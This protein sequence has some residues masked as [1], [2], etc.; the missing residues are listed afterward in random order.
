ME[1]HFILDRNL[2]G[3]DCFLWNYE[4]KDMVQSVRLIRKRRN[5]NYDFNDDKNRRR[6]LF[7]I[8]DMKAGDTFTVKNVRSIR[9]GNGM[10]P[11]FL[12][13]V[14]GRNAKVNLSKG[15]ALNEDHII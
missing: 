7:V 8:K 10:H 12:V 13:K 15:T 2:G 5:I 1:K 4:F 6:S 14:L 3:I 11:K 9:P